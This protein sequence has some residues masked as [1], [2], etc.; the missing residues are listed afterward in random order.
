MWRESSLKKGR[1]L[2]A[3]GVGLNCNWLKWVLVKNGPSLVWRKQ[4]ENMK[5]IRRKVSAIKIEINL[6]YWHWR[7]SQSTGGIP[8]LISILIKE[9]FLL[10]QSIYSNC[11]FQKLGP[12]YDKEPFHR[13][14]TDPTPRA[15]RNRPLETWIHQSGSNYPCPPTQS[16]TSPA[17]LAISSTAKR[18][19]L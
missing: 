6:G 11:Y 14:V 3:L 5:W 2:S 7:V 8:K 15:D 18:Y 9:T 19:V 17:K 4:L 13:K 1:F 12:F 10:T 16:I